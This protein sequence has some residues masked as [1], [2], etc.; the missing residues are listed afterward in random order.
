MA[1]KCRFPV[2][3]V[4]LKKLFIEYCIQNN[5]IPTIEKN[6]PEYECSSSPSPNTFLISYNEHYNI[7]FVQN[8][9]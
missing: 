7:S 1:T 5:T 3:M 9:N 4:I 2:L 8:I 6:L